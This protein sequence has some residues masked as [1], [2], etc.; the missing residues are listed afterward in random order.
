MNIFYSLIAEG[1]SSPG[2][3][4]GGS[5]WSLTIMLV[6]FMGIFYFLIIMPQ[7]KK[8]KAMENMMN[9]IQKGDKVITIGGIHGKIVSIKDNKIT[10]KIDANAEI[11]FEK[12]AISR[13]VSGENNQV[14]QV[15]K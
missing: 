8:K 10:L 13:V 2:G 14:K 12:S 6:V 4:F 7:N 3:L 11:T 1:S 5:P 15:K 9:A